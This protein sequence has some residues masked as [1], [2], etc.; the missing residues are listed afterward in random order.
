M[1]RQHP[2]YALNGSYYVYVFDD[3]P[4]SEDASTWLSSSN[5]IGVM[6]VL[7]GGDMM[8][9]NLLVAGSIPLTRTLQTLVKSGEIEDMS[10]D[11][12]IPYLTEHLTWRISKDGAEV[13]IS[14]VSGFKASVYSS[15]LTTPKSVNQLPQWSEFVPQVVVTK[16]KTGGAVSADS[17]DNS[18]N[19]GSSS[20]SS[21]DSSGSSSGSA[22]DS[23]SG[24]DSPD[25][26]YV[27]V[28]MTSTVYACAATSTLAY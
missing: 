6:G 13:D 28:K 24:S 11:N 14:N 27:T 21:S 9:L 25:V 12:C 15:T 4:A 26:V 5:L 8:N 18:T 23:S 16:G 7:A 20:G 10:E 1:Q 3:A 19:S 22:S 2:R 17:S